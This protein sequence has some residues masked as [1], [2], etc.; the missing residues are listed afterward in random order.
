MFKIILIL[1]F[2]T[3]ILL[4]DDGPVRLED[5]HII[6]L[7]HKKIKLIRE[8]IVFEISRYS[9]ESTVNIGFEF[10]NSDNPEEL[11]IGFISPPDPIYEN[12]NNPNPNDKNLPQ[13]IN[14]EAYVND[15]SADYQVTTILKTD[16]YQL[17][18][19]I[20]PNDLVFYFKAL[21]KKGKNIIKHKY[22][23]RHLEDIEEKA[24]EYR[25]KTG[26][27]WADSEIEDFQLKIIPTDFEYFQI[28]TLLQSNCILDY[29]YIEGEGKKNNMTSNRTNICIKKGFLV[30]QKKNFIPDNDLIIKLIF[31]FGLGH[32]YYNINYDEFI[33]NDTKLNKMTLEELQIL[34]NKFYALA[35]YKF[36]TPALFEYFSKFVWYW[37]LSKFSS[38]ELYKEFP[39]NIKVFLTKIKQLEEM[40]INLKN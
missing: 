2:I 22:N 36:K 26:T 7:Q 5:Y 40:K 6:P 31:P 32:D 39:D 37:P 33:I 8:N 11:Y 23:Y 12:L 3:N 18:G 17:N 4:A 21:L 38:E 15:E 14:F 9:D 27:L 16:L 13:I 25:L 10:Y 30:Y 24:Y 1:I 29:W 20:Q 35:G 34:R 28:P 19:Q